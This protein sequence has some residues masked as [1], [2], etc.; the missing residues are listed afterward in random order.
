MEVDGVAPVPAVKHAFP[1]ES[2][3]FAVDADSVKASEKSVEPVPAS[4][5]WSRVEACELV[6]A[7]NASPDCAGTNNSDNAKQTR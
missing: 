7:A 4:N 2:H 3:A 1:T 6:R 5:V